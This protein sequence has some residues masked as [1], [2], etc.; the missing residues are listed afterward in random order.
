[1]AAALLFARSRAEQAFSRELTSQLEEVREELAVAGRRLEK[2][3]E[4]HRRRGEDLVD[5][6]KRLDK[7]KRSRGGERERERAEPGRVAALERAIE[8]QT[9]DLARARTERDGALAELAKVHAQLER[10]REDARKP[11]EEADEAMRE[12]ETKL[13]QAQ[14]DLER[15]VADLDAARHELG[16]WRKRAENLD[17]V[18][19]VLRGEFE[20]AK[21]RLRAQDAELER[22]RALKVALVD[23][24]P[25]IG[26]D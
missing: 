19:M 11:R 13:G 24:V 20:L 6:R 4:E 12:L 3:K 26:E 21:D 5:L 14:A 15:T 23:P 1:L 18:Y 17:K 7:A 8:L 22:L 9:E 16:R 25:E 10:A 2:Q